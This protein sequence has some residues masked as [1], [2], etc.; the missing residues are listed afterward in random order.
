MPS[1]FPPQEFESSVIHGTHI[2]CHG[3]FFQYCEK[4]HS[5]PCA[6]V[7]CTRERLRE[8]LAGVQPFF[9]CFWSRSRFKMYVGSLHWIGV[10][11]CLAKVRVHQHSLRSFHSVSAR[12]NLFYVRS[13]YTICIFAL[14]RIPQWISSNSTGIILVLTS[15][16]SSF[17][18]PLMT[19]FGLNHNP[20]FTIE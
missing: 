14:V 15:F 7:L 4:A 19:M 18:G 10:L 20:R 2:T 1:R 11:F 17:L 5:W 13:H 6:A 8:L 12:N 3:N 16:L 9:F